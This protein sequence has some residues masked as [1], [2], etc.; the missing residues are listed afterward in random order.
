MGRL[1]DDMNRLNEEIHT[2]GSARKA[3]I[4]DLGRDRE[5]RRAEVD[6]MQAD[7]RRVRREMSRE[8]RNN[9]NE[10]VTD[11]QSQVSGLA[12]AT[13][14]RLS[15]FHHAREEESRVIRDE[16][17]EAVRNIKQAVNGLAGD[18]AEMRGR[19]RKEH[20]NASQ[21]SRAERDIFIADLSGGIESLRADIARLRAGFTEDI[22][23]AREAW[24]GKPGPRKEARPALTPTQEEPKAREEGT[25]LRSEQ[26]E[27]EEL[28]ASS[29]PEPE[30]E[31]DDLTRIQGIGPGREKLLNEAGIYTF[32]QIAESTPKSLCEA[33]GEASRIAGVEKWIEQARKRP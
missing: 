12:T 15:Q 10:F 26:P 5:R 9:L 13:A 27:E 31:P 18:T 21:A 16:L 4:R 6:D 32:S 8:T 23:Q 30:V 33:L 3:L 20:K 14:K 22:Q 24:R 7:F 11:I 28:V 25:V 19:F 17:Q 1:A 29:Q 2:A